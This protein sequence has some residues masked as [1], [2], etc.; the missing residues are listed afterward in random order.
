MGS[1]KTYL[2][3]VLLFA[4]T[5]GVAQNMRFVS[6]PVV[7]AGKF[8]SVSSPVS[9]DTTT[10]CLLVSSGASVLNTTNHAKGAFGTS[11][12]EVPPVAALA[13]LTTL[14]LFPNP[15]H[16]FTTLKCDGQ[17]DNNLSCQVRVM[18]VD[19]RML[20]SQMVLMKDIVAGYRIAVSSY[21]V[22]T[23]VISLDFMNQHY[24]R[25]LIKL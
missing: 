18:T 14:N 5:A 21:A 11:C 8:L 17:F 19:G 16:D 23:Y 15:A 25:K 20:S 6:T 10:K 9:I 7:S 1:R 4:C 12:T 13:S 2:F 3:V 24:A 22:G